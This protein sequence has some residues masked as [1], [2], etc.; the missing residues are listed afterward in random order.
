MPLFTYR[1]RP[2]VH[3]DLPLDRSA[4]ES[5]V[6]SPDR[7]ALHWFFPFIFS[8]VETHKIGPLESGGFTFKPIKRRQIA[9]AGHADSHIFAHYSD[10]ISERYEAILADR[11]LTRCV[12]A[13]RKMG[14]ASNVHHAKEVFD[15]ISTQSECYALAMDV[16]DFF[17]NLNHTLLKAVW[18]DCI[19]AHR[20]S[21]D[22][23]AVFKAITRYCQVERDA[24]FDAIHIPKNDPRLQGNHRLPTF[25][26]DGS[27]IPDN[28][29]RLCT[30]RRFREWVRDRGILRVNTTGKGIPQ[31][32]PISAIL[33]NI[34]MLALDSALHAFAQANGG[35]YR[36]YCD[37]ILVVLPTPALRDQAR[38]LIEQHLQGLRLQFNPSKTEQVDF[39]AFRP[40]AGKPL[41][42]LGFTFDGT[43]K[44]I[45]PASVARFYRKMPR[46]VLRAKLHRQRADELA[47]LTEP[48]PLKKKKL[49]RLYSY[50]GKKLGRNM[51]EKRN[52][53]SYAFDAARIMNDTGIKKQVKNH[54]PKLQEE[55]AKPLEP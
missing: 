40:I 26:H 28:P 14:S 23:F 5:L 54:W 35:M 36:R 18:S 29:N 21:P 10:I 13:F 37:D 44:R 32:S 45:R 3:F 33:S 30:P 15:F 48:S 9:Y 38:Q 17:G 41:Q 7:V 43:H 24:L 22:H 52:F 12:I 25:R 4:A 27:L 20:L 46:G 55:I 6:T 34:Y 2:Y 1:H 31:G 53:L 51:E 39:P 8:V 47:G 19:G 49:Y 16:T 42:Y 50:L 11:S